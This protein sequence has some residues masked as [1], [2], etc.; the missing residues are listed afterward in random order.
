VTFVV[1]GNDAGGAELLCA[2]A[3][4]H[5]AEATWHLFCKADAPMAAIAVKRGLTTSEPDNISDT[6]DAIEYDALLFGT[7]W[8]E[9]YERP[10]VSHAKA[11]DIPTFAF[12][13][14]W[15][16]YRERFGY[17]DAGWETNLP[18]FTVVHDEK[19]M[20]LAEGFGLPHPVAL[21]NLYLQEIVETACPQEEQSTL[22]FFGEPT[23]K[24]AKAHYGDENYWG[25]TQYSA[26]ESI[27]QHFNRFGCE[28][29]NIRLHPSEKGSGYKKVLKKFPGIRVR[30]SDAQ[31]FDLTDQ[32]MQSK[33]V[34]GFD[35]MALYIAAHL[36]KPVISFLPS[37]RREFL[38][39]LPPLR[40]IRDLSQV[41]APLLEPLQLGCE[42]FGMDFALF[43]QLIKEFRPA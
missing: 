18:D 14:H 1:V 12:L 2:F 38:L 43:T 4:K 20:A 27:L 40:Q 22:L 7:G 39:P 17:P 24:V 10:F 32:I 3:A 34:I 16:K 30:I 26:L 19:A 8:Q 37:T 29:L 42:E 15:S 13:D 35:T 5:A 31:T 41:K 33:V 23:D 21:P 9:R 28:S 6:L 11:R 25:F 36:N